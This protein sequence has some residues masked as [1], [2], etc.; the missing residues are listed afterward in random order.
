M[1]Q[2]LYTPTHAEKL[3]FEKNDNVQ[4]YYGI[5]HTGEKFFCYIRCNLQG[6]KK[7][8]ED[9]FNK[10]AAYPEEYGEIIYKDTIPSPDSKAKAFL[11]DY[12]KNNS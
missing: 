6:Y 3:S 1:S 4:L 12:L 2:I 8:Q 11:A 5:E 10:K 7:M 9:F